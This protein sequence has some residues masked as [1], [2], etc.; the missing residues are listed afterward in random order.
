MSI[1]AWLVAIAIPLGLDLYL[2]VPDD[3]PLTREKVELG[4]RLFRDRRL[5]RDGSLSCASCHRS[6]RA[7]SD[8]RSVSA[9]SNGCQVFIPSVAPTCAV[10]SRP[11]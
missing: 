4:R 6:D 10:Q 1:V 11:S 8:A 9:G 5:S 2:P 7:F 3:N